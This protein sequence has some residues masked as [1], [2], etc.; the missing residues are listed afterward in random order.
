M[1]DGLLEAMRVAGLDPV[2]GQGAFPEMKA[3]TVFLLQ[4]LAEASGGT[5]KWQ[6]RPE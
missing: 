3:D 1:A 2:A 4:G 6:R 5:Y